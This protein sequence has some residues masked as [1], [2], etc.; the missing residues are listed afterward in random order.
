MAKK[1]NKIKGQDKFVDLVQQKTTNGY[2]YLD[3]EDDAKLADPSYIPGH[4]QIELRP[5]IRGKRAE[6]DQL[7][8]IME[9]VD[10]ASDEYGAAEIGREKVAQSLI[11]AK[12]QIEDYKKGTGILKQALGAMNKGTQDSHLYT[13]MLVFGAQSDGIS[14]DNDGRLSFAG[15]YGDKNNVSV[16]KMDDVKNPMGGGSPVITEPFESKM[17]VWKLAEETK[18]KKD[19]KKDFDYDWMY[20]RLHNDLTERGHQNTIGMAFTDLAGDNKGRSF[21]QQYDEGLAD[22]LYYQHPETGD[23]LGPDSSWMKNPENAEVL[24]KFLSKYLTDVMNDVHGKV[25]EQTLQVQKTPADLAK[26]IIKKYSK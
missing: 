19:L 15:V 10:K 13:N 18:R 25:D 21:A 6:F 23:A 8:E 4:L 7:T 20:T 26:E 11:T 1:Q 17:F 22:P 3:A 14:F 16:F 2:N 24:K 12:S 5:W 9:S